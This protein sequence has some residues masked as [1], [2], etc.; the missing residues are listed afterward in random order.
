MREALTF[1]TQNDLDD[2]RLV[3]EFVTSTSLAPHESHYRGGEGP[4]DKP[5]APDPHVAARSLL[6]LHN[7]TLVTR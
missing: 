6:G 1:T 7:S 2:T 4:A 5:A 3:V